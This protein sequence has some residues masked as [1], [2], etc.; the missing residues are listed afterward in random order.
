MDRSDLE[1]LDELRVIALNGL[2]YADDSY[3]EERYDR[4]LELVSDRYGELADLPT[5]EV[6]DRFES[7]LGHVTPNVG[8]RAVV[9]DDEG[10]VLLMKRA[11]DGAWGLPGGY[12]EPGETPAETAVREAREETGLTVRPDDLVTFAYRAPDA[13]NPHGFV[14]AVYRCSVTGGSR[15]LSHE[16]DALRY[17]DVDEVP[18]W[19]ADDERVTRDAVASGR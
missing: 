12:A 16:G 19:H 11:D 13:G 9:A 3:D 6:R 17:W 7:R 4:I 5:A 18:E 15:E 2:E 8:A 10:R 14:G 1:L